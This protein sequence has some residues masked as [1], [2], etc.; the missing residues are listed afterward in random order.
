[1]EETEQIKMTEKEVSDAEIAEQKAA[2]AKLGKDTRFNQLVHE[3]S[4]DDRRKNKLHSQ[5]ERRKNI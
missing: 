1:M 3:L 2:F 4:V 5:Y